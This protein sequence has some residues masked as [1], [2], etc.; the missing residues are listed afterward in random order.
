MTN[1]ALN[2]DRGLTWLAEGWR[3][4]QLNI[5]MWIALF[6][7]YAIVVVV[8]H[9]LPL[10]GWLL[11]PLV[12]PALAAG[13]LGA[14]RD[15]DDGRDIALETLFAPMQDP[16][17]RAALL[18]L[19]AIYLAGVVALMLLG[20]AIGGSALLGGAM[21]GGGGAMAAVLGT[22]FF[23]FMVGGL[24]LAVLA[25]VVFY[26]IPLVTFRNVA[27][28]DA[29]KQS[30][31]GLLKHWLP[32]LVYG[33]ITVVLAVIAS[34][35]A[36]LGWLVLGPVLFGGMYASYKDLFPLQDATPAAPPVV[37]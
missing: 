17:R 26:A 10:V 35:P 27:P 37:Q 12:T 4:F 8:A 1:E 29:L 36:L 20:F 34:M 18:T 13:M 25:S 24:L 6:V 3:L 15:L 32:L 16:T 33:V 7:I 23:M 21:L 28:M 2:A 5:G 22:G 9:G 19:G 30:L 11:G 31:N 14:A